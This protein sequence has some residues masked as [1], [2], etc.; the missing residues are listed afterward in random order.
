MNINNVISSSCD[1]FRRGKFTDCC[2]LLQNTVDNCHLHKITTND[3]VEYIILR[4]NL[5][6]SDSL[7]CIN[8]AY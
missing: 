6:V 2:D 1:L 4:N 5:L 3:E 8:Y 7:V